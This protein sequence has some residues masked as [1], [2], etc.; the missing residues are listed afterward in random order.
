MLKGTEHESRPPQKSPCP[1]RAQSASIH[2]PR[3]MLPMGIVA[4]T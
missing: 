2:R 4:L 3:G 1:V